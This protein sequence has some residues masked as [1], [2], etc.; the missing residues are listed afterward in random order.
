MHV[1]KNL[2]DM[3]PIQNVLRQG[4]GLSHLILNS[5]SIYPIRKVQENQEGFELNGTC[6]FFLVINIETQLIV[7]KNENQF[8]FIYL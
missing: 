2:T 4:D 8:Y 5:T 7:I 6:R 3:F 1:G